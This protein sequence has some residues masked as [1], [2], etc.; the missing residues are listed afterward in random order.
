MYFQN[1]LDFVSISHD[2]S[3]DRNFMSRIAAIDFNIAKLGNPMEPCL[4]MLSAFQRI[5]GR[6]FLPNTQQWKFLIHCNRFTFRNRKNQC[7][8]FHEN[9][10]AIRIKW[11]SLVLHQYALLAIKYDIDLQWYHSTSAGHCLMKNGIRCE[12]GCSGYFTS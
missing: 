6:K 2:M 11:H 9:D 4:F 12:R 1:L 3:Y 10:I 5:N 7:V 8:I